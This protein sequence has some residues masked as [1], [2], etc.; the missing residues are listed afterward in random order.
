L[1]NSKDRKLFINAKNDQFNYVPMLAISPSEMT[2]LEELPSKDK[3]LLLPIFKLKGWVAS[4]HLDKTI[5]RIEKAIDKRPWIADIDQS[6]VLEN[7]EFL[8]TGKLPDR[9]VFEE[10]NQ[11]LNAN[12]GF[13]AWVE[14]L[15][16]LPTAIPTIQWGRLSELEKQ[17]IQLKDLNRGIVLSITQSN[18]PQEVSLALKVIRENKIPDVHVMIDLGKIDHRIMN[19]VVPL[20]ARVNEIAGSLPDC[21]VSV[22]GSSF[23]SQFSGYNNG[24][25][26]IYERLLFNKLST[27]LPAITLIYSDRGGA[28]AEK[29]SGGGGI[30]SPRIDY[31][32]KNDWRFIR[33]EYD[34]PQ[35]PMGG[36]K[37]RL[38]SSIAKE[39]MDEEYWNSELKLWGTQ[40][41]D[42]TSKGDEY[43]INSPAK[44]TAA[45]INI[46]LHL[47]LHYQ[48]E[49][50]IIDT[51]DDWVD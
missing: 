35:S 28:R 36:E 17:I 23:P 33:K 20:I 25:N 16:R 27:S 42:L 32:L 37:E 6:F 30:P 21:S 19:Q 47:Q 24:E 1:V 50:S 4:H 51:D 31:P 3:D 12:N 26:T 43:G 46:H 18:T 45:R 44:A 49:N 48:N 38:Y 39:L 14:Y 41:I 13:S 2:A 22:S 5:T 9:P 29:L 7:T 15:K 10:V 34:D 8:I 11:L 40:L